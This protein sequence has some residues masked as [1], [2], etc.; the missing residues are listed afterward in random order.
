M[1]ENQEERK[2]VAKRFLSPHSSAAQPP[3]AKREQIFTSPFG[4]TGTSSSDAVNSMQ[5]QQQ[6]QQQQQ[7]QHQ[8]QQQQPA[9]ATATTA[10]ATAARICEYGGHR[11]TYARAP[12]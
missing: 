5:Q 4:S 2:A 10:A 1:E 11:M 3:E 7:T 6:Q 8:T 12:Y 9:T